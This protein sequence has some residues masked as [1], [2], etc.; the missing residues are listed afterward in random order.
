M[1]DNKNMDPMQLMR[2]WFVQSE[3]M[4]SD[5]MS[6]VMADERVAEGSG[7]FMQEALHTQR[8]F[9]ESMG[10]YLS[11]MNMPSRTDI[12]DLKDR[13]SQME[14]SVNMVL[15][16]LREMRAEKPATAATAAQKKKPTRTKKAAP[17]KAAAKKTA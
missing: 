8:M 10:Q 7:R 11:N 16:E 1:A 14:D 13:V 9:S 4:W 5:A 3:K 2:D 12:L 17:K 15:V 6:E